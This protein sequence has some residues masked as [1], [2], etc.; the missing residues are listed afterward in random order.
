MLH[1]WLGE[2]RTRD[3]GSRQFAAYH[4]LVVVTV[5]I[6]MDIAGAP[7]LRNA[8]VYN[9]RRPNARLASNLMR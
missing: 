9:R 4:N 1:D 6:R 3:R 2:A 5:A 7:I 8:H